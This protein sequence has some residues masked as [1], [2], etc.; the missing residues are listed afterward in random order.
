MSVTFEDRPFPTM[1]RMA[2]TALANSHR[3]I[4]QAVL[5]GEADVTALLAPSAADAK[6]SFTS[7]LIKRVAIALARHPNF[8]AVYADGLRRSFDRIDIGLAVAGSDGTLSVPVVRDAANLGLPEIDRQRHDLQERAKAKR[9][10][11]DDLNGAALTISNIS[12][13][14]SAR[15]AVPIIPYG[16]G[17]ILVVSAARAGASERRLVCLSFA[18]DHRVNN[19]MPAAAFFDDL[20]YELETSERALG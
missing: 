6:A 8:N 12:A 14:R 7:V 13:S 20:V 1:Q 10:R 17:S 15:F 18:F 2:N 19:G 11:V 16:Q 3:E 4:P 9:L 5:F